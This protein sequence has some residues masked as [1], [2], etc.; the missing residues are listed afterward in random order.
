[1]YLENELIACKKCKIE[2]ENLAESQ[3]V[4]PADL[5]ILKHPRRILQTNFPIIMDDGSTKIITAFRVQYNDD[6]G[7]GKGG[8]RFHQSV[9][10]DEVTELAFTMALKTSLAGLPFGGAKGGVRINPKDF[11]EAEL[12]KISRGYVREFYKFLGPQTDIPAPDVNTNPQIMAWMLDE[13]EKI[14]GEKTPAFI[15]GKPVE[16]GGSEGRDKSTAMGA[17]YILQ[18]EYKNEQ[19]K[20]K[21]KVAIQGFG[22]AGSVV[23]RLLSD[24]GFSVVAVSDVSGGIYNKEG[25][26][27]EKLEK[28]I[29]EEKN[30]SVIGFSGGEEI[31]NK[32]LLEL[33]VDL[34]IPAALGDVITKENVEN[35]KADKILELANGPISVEAEKVLLEKKVRII[36]DLLANAGGV[37]VSYFEWVQ[38]LENEHWSLEDVN[39]KLKKK[40]I[41]AYRKVLNLAEEKNIPLKKAAY[42]IAM[43]RIFSAKKKN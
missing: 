37:I 28:F 13:Y 29:Y 17:F 18:E 26:D 25:L 41:T 9:D 5:K 16:E 1:M 23:A 11:S 39:K 6:L 32:E 15:T 10:L 8:I 42:I 21:I 7:P 27:I 24:E 36:P 40:I 34:L 3:L 33:D 30:P 12:E 38:N 22:N 14:T 19:D 20:S 43:E 4:S 31:T 35:I 2:V